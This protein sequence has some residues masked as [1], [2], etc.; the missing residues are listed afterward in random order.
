[1]NIVLACGPFDYY[2]YFF[3]SCL[4]PAAPTDLA[5]LCRSIYNRDPL[6]SPSLWSIGEGIRR[7]IYTGSI[8]V[9]LTKTET[10]DLRPFAEDGAHYILCTSVQQNLLWYP[11][12]MLPVLR[13][14]EK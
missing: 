6:S 12:A 2:Y 8:G 13:K 9:I 14:K 1:M 3:F 11:S 5:K 10:K 4:F 7:W